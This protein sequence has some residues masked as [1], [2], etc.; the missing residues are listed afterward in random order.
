LFLVILLGLAIPL[1]LAVYALILHALNRRPQPVLVPGAWDFALVLFASSGFLLFGGPAVLAGFHERARDYLLLGR[2]L[3]VYEWRSWLGAWIAYALGVVALSFVLAARRRRATAVY[4]VEA[5]AFRQA[6]GEA[7]DRLHLE[8]LRDADQVFITAPDEPGGKPRQAV[9]VRLDAF[10]PLRH[11]TLYWPKDAGGLR[12][13][14]ETELEQALATVYTRGNPVA[15][16][17]F[18]IAGSLFALM[19][20]T[21]VLMI[22]FLYFLSRPPS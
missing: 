16:W 1:P 4:N 14:V 20:F 2:R 19:F 22:V 13:E 12:H 10:A 17:M 6:L 21:A 15:A 3:D 8:W 7:L 5:V 11:V 9:V 18:S